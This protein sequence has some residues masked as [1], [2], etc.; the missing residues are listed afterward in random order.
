MPQLE[1]IKDEAPVVLTTEEK[2]VKV[3]VD[4]TSDSEGEDE[5]AGGSAEALQSRAEKKARKLIQKLGLKQVPS[6]TRVTLR[7]PK[8]VCALCVL[9]DISFSFSSGK[10]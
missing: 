8:N 3:G 2:Q 1:E 5:L 7:R 6:I 9:W 10:R 4:A